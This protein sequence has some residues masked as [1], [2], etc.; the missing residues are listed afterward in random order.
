M[1]DAT[2]SRDD[3]EGHDHL[4]C[5]PERKRRISLF[6]ARWLGAERSFACAQ[7]DRETSHLRRYREHV[8]IAVV[9]D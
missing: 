3:D 4:P 6:D 9:D 8:K 2:K 7:D 1:H 5:H